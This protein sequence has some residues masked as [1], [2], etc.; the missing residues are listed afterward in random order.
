MSFPWA[1][2]APGSNS[3]SAERQSLQQ[4]EGSCPRGSDVL[5]QHTEGIQVQGAPGSPQL[6]HQLQCWLRRTTVVAI[7]SQLSSPRI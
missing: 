4:A 3:C 5:T 1:T 2:T 7:C 6:P